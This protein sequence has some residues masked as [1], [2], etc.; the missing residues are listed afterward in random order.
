[1]SEIDP[2]S[3]GM[4]L[5]AAARLA[6]F[7]AKDGWP[8]SLTPA[9]LG[10]LQYPTEGDKQERWMAIR[11]RND[12]IAIVNSAIE[13]GQ[14]STVAVEQNADAQQGVSTMH[15]GAAAPARTRGESWEISWA[16]LSPE[17]RE[18]FYAENGLEPSELFDKSYLAPL[19]WTG[20]KAASGTL[21]RITREACVSWFSA[22]TTRE[23]PRSEYVRAWLG[24]LW[25]GGKAAENERVGAGGTA[26]DDVGK[27]KAGIDGAS[28]AMS[29]KLEGITDLLQL[30]IEKIA[31]GVAALQ[32]KETDMQKAGR[33]MESFKRERADYV[34]RG[35][36][37]T[38]DGFYKRWA[39]KEGCGADNIKRLLSIAR[40]QEG[41]SRP[42][43]SPTNQL[44]NPFNL[45]K[46]G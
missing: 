22:T 24:D 32:P 44:P 38:S 40:K 16:L 20:P 46:S 43:A 11:L 9:Q 45:K 5:Q 17:L 15:A 13:A 1:M 37:F 21:H 30:S 42:L 14:L 6:S 26:P 31:V 35:E 18:E 12:F 10:R 34:V 28:E 41:Q 19:L 8:E 36:K 7:P 2:R 3:P 25:P 23:I 33:L 29:A 4:L 39:I 27:A